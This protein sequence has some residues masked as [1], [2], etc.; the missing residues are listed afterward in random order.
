M[1]VQFQNA[2]TFLTGN[3]LKKHIRLLYPV[4]FFSSKI[5]IVH[6]NHETQNIKITIFN[7][8]TLC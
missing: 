6:K 3:R 4:I 7:N 8:L 5:A 2:L 1:L